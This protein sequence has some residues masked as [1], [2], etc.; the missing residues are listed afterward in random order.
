MLKLLLGDCLNVMKNIEPL[1]ID[2]ILTDPPYNISKENNFNTMGRQG[3]DFGEWDKDFNL[4]SWIDITSNLL[5][6]NG[7]M[8]IFNDWK[9]IGEISKYAERNGFDIKDMLRWEKLNPMPRNINRRY[10]T[11]FEIAVWLVKKKSKWTFNKIDEKYQRPKFVGGLTPKSEK[12]FGKHPT[13]KP[14]FLMERLITIHSNIRETILDPFMGVGT[15]GV[16]CKNL[17]RSFIGIEKDETFFEI[18]KNRI[19]EFINE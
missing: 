12:S 8:I 1:S 17:N 16:A 3:I 9:N 19:K 7:S 10:V 13:Q 15:T 14:I 5:S 11:D 2:L 6:K 18:S 4:L